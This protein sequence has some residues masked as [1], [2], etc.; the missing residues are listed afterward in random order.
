MS[1]APQPLVSCIMPT[2]NRRA[3]VR[4][5]IRYFL[6]QDY[7]PKE[8]I[9]VDDGTDAV[10]ELMP[11]EGR[12]RYVRLSQRMSVG[13]KRNLAC[14]QARGEII[15]HWDDDDWHAPRRLRYQ[16][17]AL[18][19]E[20]TEVCGIQ[21]LLFFD[22]AAQRAWRYVYP[23]TQRFWLAGSTLCY[24]RDFWAR[25]R[26]A[27]VNVGEDA[28]FVW[29]GRPERMTV[30]PDHTFHVGL[31]HA[32]NVS[33]KQTAGVYWRPEPFAEIR[34]LLGA[35]WQF[36]ARGQAGDEYADADANEDAPS[37][38][39]S[40]AYGIGDI[41]R[42]T[43]LVRALAR[44]GYRV[45]VLVAPDYPEV[46]QLLA[47][48]PEI[49]R[50]FLYENL[51]SN[52]GAQP[53]PG[54]E[55]GDYD[56]A[57]FT[58]WSAP[59]GRWVRAR[60]TFA[61]QQSHWLKA[62]DSACVERIAREVGWQDE[63]PEPFAIPSARR[64]GLPPGAVAL[65][66]GCKPDWPWKKWHGFD[67]LAET[68]L[69]PV[70]I[71][72]QSDLQ[73]EH[74]YFRREFNWPEHAQ[75][76][77]GALSL[78]DTAAL[79][80]ECAAL[81]SND[82]GMMHLGVA[83]RTPTFGIFGIT[84]PAREIIPS[85]KMFPLSKGL[86]C[87]PA[88]RKGRWGRRDC[89]RHLE[90]LKSLTAQE[91]FAHMRAKLGR[92]LERPAARRAARAAG[93]IGLVYHGY[94]FDASGYGQAARAY[95]HALH[96]AG[97]ALSVVDLQTGPRQT[98]DAL[99]ESLLGAPV[100]ADFHLFH[101]IPPQWSRHAARYKNAIGM[102]VWET[103]SMP[104]QWRSALSRCLDVW[105][106]CDYNASV[107]GAA[108]GRPVFKLPHPLPAAPPDYGAAQAAELPGVRPGDFVFYSI[109]E[110]QERK[111]PQGIIEAFMRA[112]DAE[113]EIVLFIKSSLAAA[114][115]AEQALGQARRATGSRARVVI[116]CEA[117]PE[118][119]I[120]ALHRRGDCYVSLHRGEGWCY[121]LFDAAGR[122]KP[123]VATAYSGPLEY[124]S[125]EEHF[126]VRYRL[127][128]VGQLYRYYHHGMRWAEPDLEHAAQQ[129]R[130]AYEGRADARARAATAARRIRETYSQEA[131]G[132]LARGQLL[133]LLRQ[134]QPL[135]WKSLAGKECKRQ[136]ITDIP[137]PGAWYDADYFERGLKSNW[138]RGYN[139][140]LFADLF[141]RTATFLTGVFVESASFLDVGCAKGFLVRAL[142]EQ[143][144]ECWGFDHSR[145]A[146]ERADAAVGP[147]LTLAGV[148]DFNFEREFDVLLA[149]NVFESLTEAQLAL[150]L[151][152]A[153]QWTRHAL[154]ATIP[155]FDSEEERRRARAGDADLS[156]ITMQTRRW[157]HE[158]FLAAGWRQDALHRLVQ[159]ACQN[160]PLPAA[161]RWKIY[162]YA[163]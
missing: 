86:P 145:W 132:A 35:D 87:E 51:R 141:R 38:L 151:A 13:A 44:M 11:D 92:D 91:V 162:V 130:A 90:C 30:L 67:E 100:E 120:E 53:V 60:R 98:R 137:I 49:S 116:R 136:M 89:E 27:D 4:Q 46:A 15:A 99:V 149:F 146:V 88:C 6:R 159:R 19:R 124:L 29:N 65:H 23:P 56:V 147:Y 133:A 73:N 12:V 83:V 121:P 144:K 108:L 109:F 97:V 57:A 37:A 143:G 16:V 135:K 36:Y 61:F 148:D 50:L 110:W 160:H 17:E 2:H 39:V 128:P 103:D 45:D 71:G 10:G 52:K 58:V 25:N 7:E 95:I 138:E 55:G 77:V 74:T 112:F 14:E 32:H 161:M 59:L 78:P 154:V 62:G 93:E 54:F 152:R 20:G 156:H 126:L 42:V 118:E 8:L 85:A 3:L 101:G 68:L 31:I 72:T 115:Q 102:T 140:Q 119:K 79:L 66:P 48:A 127:G 131:V 94:V 69:H 134:S 114:R 111:S 64:F 26:F 75:N 28:R 70:V 125:A 22:A 5:A 9:V 63:L 24:R 96:G 157:W 33:R 107:F 129:M 81:V 139:W 1:A 18:V 104:A 82:S 80:R 113:G 34:R 153:R 40:A 76:F 122:G 163:P 150:F 21:Q 84:S 142:R 123:V 41:I 106:P 155:S 43:P 117:W 158:L 105:L 47:G